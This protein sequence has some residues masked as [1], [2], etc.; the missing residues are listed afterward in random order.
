MNAVNADPTS[1]DP[2]GTGTAMTNNENGTATATGLAAGY[3]MIEDVT[4][5]LPAGEAASKIMFQV[6]G[7]TEV[8][9][10]HPKTTIVKKVVQD[11]NDSTG[12]QPKD[13]DSV[14]IDSADYDIGDTVPFKS[15][16][17]FAGLDNYDTY[18]VIFTDIMA[19]GLTY[20]S[21]MVISVN[22]KPAPE[23][24]FTI[25]TST[26]TN[27]DDAAYNGGTMITVTCNNIKD[28]EGVTT[29]ATI[30]LDYSATLNSKA[31]F[32]APGNPN[33]IKVTTTH[34]GEGETPWDVNIVFTYKTDVNKVDQ[35]K[36]PLT[37]AEFA[38]EKFVKSTNGTVTYKGVTGEW[39][40]LQLVKNDAGTV[41][42]FKG[43]DDGY[44][45]IRETKTPAGYNT[46]DDIYFEVTATHDVVAENPA[47]TNLAATANKPDGTAYTEED[48]E[49][50]KVATFTVTKNDGLLKTDVENKSGTVLPETGGMGT[51]IFYALGGMMVLVAVVLLVTKKRMAS[52]E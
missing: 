45:R 8:T 1:I 11:I 19:P 51:T 30:V 52:A 20:K 27:A 16:A 37:G 17:T 48:I 36:K 13:G 38:L 49:A 3:Y 28:I 46:I 14:W 44:Y 15:T 39:T 6:V 10:K 24:A 35:N 50:G 31:Q 41:F 23:G 26:Y 29:S 9:S 4:T 43:L 21:D 32:G 12:V 7:N 34:E 33:K 40:T 25:A 22:G 47:L 42:S 5:N 2:T 18:K